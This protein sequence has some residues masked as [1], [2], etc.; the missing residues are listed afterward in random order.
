MA[1]WSRVIK[2]SI[3]LFLS[4]VTSAYAQQPTNYE[5]HVLSDGKLDPE[6][7][8]VVVKIA[9]ADLKHLTEKALEYVERDLRAS[10]IFSPKAWMLLKDGTIKPLKIEQDAEASAPTKIK[11]VLYRAGLRSVAR[12]GQIHA[13]VIVYPGSFDKDGDKKPVV[14]IEHEHRLGVSGLK[15]VPIKMEDGV[16]QFAA[17]ISQKKPFEFFYDGG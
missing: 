6:E 9:R 8:A 3:V 13:A 7:L 2:I 11:L 4:I 15:L 16:P 17:H 12:H 10:G 5:D 14:V 1:Q